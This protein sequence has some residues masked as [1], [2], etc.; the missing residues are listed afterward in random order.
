MRVEVVEVVQHPEHVTGVVENHHTGAADHGT[1]GSQGVRIEHQIHQIH[2]DHFLG[3]IRAFALHFEF[4]AGAENLG[5]AAAGNDSFQGAPGL[6]SAADV[7]DE[8]A[9]GDLSASEFVVAGILHVAAHAKRA[10]A[11]VTGGAELG[12]FRR[13]QVDDMFDV[14]EG[15]DVVDDG[16]AIVESED[17]GEKR[18]LD[19]R[20]GTFAFERF[21]QAGLF[22]ADVGPGALVHVDVAVEAAAQHILADDSGGPRFGDGFF[23]NACGLGEF[24][25]DVDVREVHVERPGGDHHALK[26]L[27]R[28]FVE[29]VAVFEGAGFGFIAVDHEIV[30]LAV[31][32]LDKA[33]FHPG[34]EPRAAAAAE[35][36]GF[37]LGDDVGRV[38]LQ[39]FFQR[40]VAAVSQVAIDRSVIVVASDLAQNHPA[41]GRVR[42]AE[43]FAVSAVGFLQNDGGVG[44]LEA[45][46]KLV[47]HQCHGSGTA[48]GKTFDELDGVT[49]VGRVHPV[50]VVVRG[51]SSG[52]TTKRL[53]HLRRTGHGARK[54]TA[55]ADG[56]L[57]RGGLTKP[58]IKRDQ[59]EDVDRLEVELAGDPIDA[60]VVDVAKVIL[61]EV[62]KRNG[63]AAQGNRVVGDGFLDPLQKAGRN[64]VGLT[65][66]GVGHEGRYLSAKVTSAS[67]KTMLS[68]AR[69]LPKGADRCE[70]ERSKH[71]NIMSEKETKHANDKFR[72]GKAHAA[73]AANEFK[74]AASAKLNDLRDTL[75]E[76]AG[77]YR[78]RA[79][80]VWSETTG[81]A[82]TLTEDGE[83]YIRENPLQAVGIALAAG[84]V[85]GLILRR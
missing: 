74:E 6:E 22:A 50:T 25:A 56:C 66:R 21:E 61:P 39:R 54:R 34:G 15:L 2:F 68:A 79:N 27:V 38:H 19:P 57:A 28:I 5:R 33:P 16:R 52:G 12:E 69:H 10:R 41:F 82:R 30:G 13:A 42:G 65:G 80:Q 77:E 78:E 24:A 53:A 55:D 9:H 1:G 60:T 72:S 32:A 64:L 26:Q 4:F 8:L 7:V 70:D 59:L 18:R 63:C 71:P 85:L 36:G 35:V 17:G 76:R 73:E 62:Q 40:L 44:G 14:A 31:I 3:A 48:T 20:V 49:S 37:D 58:W 45:F 81:R 46:D 83:D 23:H 47:V 43:R 29:D 84:F 75:N 67:R 11:A 51:I